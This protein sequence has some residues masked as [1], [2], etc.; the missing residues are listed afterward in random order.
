MRQAKGKAQAKG[1]PTAAQGKGT[2]GSEGKTQEKAKAE[3]AAPVKVVKGMS[4]KDRLKKWDL[5]E[6]VSSKNPKIARFKT[7]GQLKEF[8]EGEI[9]AGKPSKAIAAELGCTGARVWEMMFQLG[10]ERPKKEAGR[11]KAKSEEGK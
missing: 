8:I 4:K 3:Q 1:G 7:Y 6:T 10:I 11:A 5:G 2:A 9:A